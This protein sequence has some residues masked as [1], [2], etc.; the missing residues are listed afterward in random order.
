MSQNIDTC[1]RYDSN[2]GNLRVAR[3][4]V[5][6]HG[7]DITLKKFQGILIRKVSGKLSGA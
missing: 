1:R 2:Q 5:N 3:Y 4:F 7:S 6:Y